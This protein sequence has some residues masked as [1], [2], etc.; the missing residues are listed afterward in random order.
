LT[1]LLATICAACGSSSARPATGYLPIPASL[2]TC[3]GEPLAPDPDTATTV[4]VLDW[5]S[6]LRVAGCD[7]RDKLAAV[8]ALQA[9]QKPP[10]STCTVR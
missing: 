10:A 9:G 8:R 6:D 5:T 2:L 4:D 1:P 7:C 3:R